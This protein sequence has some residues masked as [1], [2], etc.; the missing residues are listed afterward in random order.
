M[1]GIYP[2]CSKAMD[3]G[4][5]SSA[6][7]LCND[8]SLHGVKTKQGFDDLAE[9][10]TQFSFWIVTHSNVKRSSFNVKIFQETIHQKVVP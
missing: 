10:G 4:Y 9:E 7:A 3:V 5:S 6:N 8:G 1:Y 2:S